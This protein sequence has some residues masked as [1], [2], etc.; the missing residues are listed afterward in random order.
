MKIETGFVD[1]WK[2]ED[3]YKKRLAK[4]IKNIYVYVAKPALDI[5]YKWIFL[6]KE[7]AL[8]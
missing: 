2:M 3:K 7:D 5:L 4:Y 6:G 8:C 1:I